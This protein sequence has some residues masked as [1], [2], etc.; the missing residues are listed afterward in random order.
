MANMIYTVGC[1]DFDLFSQ[2]S[3]LFMY[4]WI[5]SFSLSSGIALLFRIFVSKNHWKGL[6]WAIFFSNSFKSPDLCADFLFHSE[7]VHERKLD[8]TH[9][10]WGL[11]IFFGKT[12]FRDYFYQSIFFYV[13][14]EIGINF[15]IF[16][17]LYWL[18]F[19]FF[20]TITWQPQYKVPCMNCC[21]Q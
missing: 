17:Q 21:R 3:N 6:R 2:I 4:Y 19:A 12:V 20:D 9:S 11:E 18:I 8:K 1:S 15:W 13:R 5:R 14:S 7:K 16:W 10:S